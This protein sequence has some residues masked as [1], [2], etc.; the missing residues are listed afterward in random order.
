MN[1]ILS[2]ERPFLP[3]GRET[4]SLRQFNPSEHLWRALTAHCMARSGDALG[5]PVATARSLYGGDEV[6]R[7]FIQKASVDPATTTGW[8][9]QL[10]GTAVVDAIVSLA[11]TSAAAALIS[12]GVRV[13]L[14][15]VATVYVPT[16]S[17][18]LPPPAFVP[19]AA[20]IPVVQGILATMTLRA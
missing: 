18:A 2:G 5:D 19:E 1:K 20:P 3:P 9:S 7:A 11:P 17:T 16:W 14:S 15:G 12:R 8:A 6:T 4:R 13:D 10:A